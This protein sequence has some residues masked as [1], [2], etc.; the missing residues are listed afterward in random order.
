MKSNG[1][2]CPGPSEEASA[3]EKRAEQSSGDIST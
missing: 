3:L 1:E 2:P